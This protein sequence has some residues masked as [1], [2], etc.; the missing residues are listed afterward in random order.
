MSAGDGHRASD[1]WA[2]SVPRSKFTPRPSGSLH[3]LNLAEV[4]LEPLRFVGPQWL[5]ITSLAL[6]LLEQGEKPLDLTGMRWLVGQVPGLARVTLEVEALYLVYL[7][8]DNQFPPIVAHRALDGP[9]GGE[10]RVA[11]LVLL[12]GEHASETF[13]FTPLRSRDIR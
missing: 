10:K 1:P 5:N 4:E 12:A 9:V 2:S 7:R 11:D 8:I 13:P 6:P 3:R